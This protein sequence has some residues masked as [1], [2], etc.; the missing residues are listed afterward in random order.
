MTALMTAAIG[1]ESP[2]QISSTLSVIHC[3][4]A[5]L[6]SFQSLLRHQFGIA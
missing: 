5:C 3:N 1:A 4:D 2:G 6:D